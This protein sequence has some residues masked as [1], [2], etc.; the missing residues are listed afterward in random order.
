MSRVPFI[1]SSTA[2]RIAG[3]RY[4]LH[5]AARAIGRRRDRAGKPACAVRRLA[6]RPPPAC[7]AHGVGPLS[8]TKLVRK[9]CRAPARPLWLDLTDQCHSAFLAAPVNCAL[10]ERRA[11]GRAEWP[12]TMKWELMVCKTSE[13]HHAWTQRWASHM[14]GHVLSENSPAR[15]VGASSG[16]RPYWIMSPNIITGRN[17]YL[18][19]RACAKTCGSIKL[20]AEIGDFIF[21]KLRSGYGSSSCFA[22]GGCGF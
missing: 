21:F 11:G 16:A 14:G 18:S 13:D 22:C 17:K 7:R 8:R 1:A 15:P 19:K 5:P 3:R 12:E 6:R 9:L 20:K 2:S 10:I 4:S